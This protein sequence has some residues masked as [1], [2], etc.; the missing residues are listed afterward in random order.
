MDAG[1]LR[2]GITGE[3]SMTHVIRH[4]PELMELRIPYSSTTDQF[5]FLLASDIHL[6]NPKCDRKLFA[7]HLNEMQERKGKALFFGDVM[8]LM[9]GKKDR[10]G[11]KGDIRPEHLGSNYFDLVFNE[12]ANW[13]KPWQEDI[14]MMSDGN[15]ETAIINHNEVDPLGNV[16]RIMRDSGSPVE[17]MRYQGFLW[18]T[19]YQKGLERAQEK[20]RRLTLGFHHGTWGGVI[21]RGTLGGNRYASVMPDADVLVNGH[22]HER[23]IVAHP[24]YRINNK[25]EQRIEQRWHIQTGTYKQEFKGGGGFAIEKIVMP[26]SLG[27]IFLKLR[28]R[29]SSGVEITC[30]P[31]T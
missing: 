17:H 20:I 1:W 15:H 22:N 9:Q 13:L 4:S 29:N 5:H 6:D 18:F 19:F 28:P 21:T 16:V 11:S 30:E 12:T 3:A 31:A 24:C 27:G 8:C 26:K 10:R 14:V 25:G 23:T 7:K 2:L